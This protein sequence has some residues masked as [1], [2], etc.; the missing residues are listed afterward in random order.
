V[1]EGSTSGIASSLAVLKPV[2]ALEGRL[3]VVGEAM[4][5]LSVGIG[6]GVAFVSVKGWW[7]IMI[8]S[9]DCNGP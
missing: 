2:V 7:M 4:A 1:L 6:V 3:D 9:Q 5:I 8:D